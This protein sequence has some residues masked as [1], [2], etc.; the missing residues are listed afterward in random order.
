[1]KFFAKKNRIT[2]VEPIVH[3]HF[4]LKWSRWKIELF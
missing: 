4:A 1:M 3:L 2:E